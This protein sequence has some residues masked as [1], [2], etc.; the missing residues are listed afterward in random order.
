MLE[1]AEVGV[2]ASVLVDGEDFAL[3]FREGDEGVGFA[4]GDCEG[5]FDDYCDRR[6]ASERREGREAGGR[7]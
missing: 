6:L 5:L 1:G 3:F 4:G 7:G 2:V